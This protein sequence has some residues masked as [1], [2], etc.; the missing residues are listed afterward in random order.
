MQRSAF[1]YSPCGEQHPQ[2]RVEAACLTGSSRGT[3]RRRA[4]RLLLVRAACI[5]ILGISCRPTAAEVP[6]TN[7]APVYLV[8]D[9]Q[10]IPDGDRAE[11]LLAIAHITPKSAWRSV[12]VPGPLTRVAV[13]QIIWKYVGLYRA[14]Y[15]QTM[16]ALV[17]LVWDSNIEQHSSH[18]PSTVLIPP[19]PVVGNLVYN[20][21]PKMRT[22]EPLRQAYSLSSHL[23]TLKSGAPPD[24]RPV[25]QND[26]RRGSNLTA[27]EV[28]SSAELLKEIF[29]SPALRSILKGS[30]LATTR[31][32]FAKAEV[33]AAKPTACNG[34]VD[35]LPTS[36]YRPL[37]ENARPRNTDAA[38]NSL[39]AKAKAHPLYV[40]DWDTDT[41]HGAKVIGAAGYILHSLGMDA[42]VPS[43]LPYELDPSKNGPTL[44]ALVEAFRN[45]RV[46][47]GFNAAILA[48]Y[49][50]NTI[51]WIDNPPKPDP[52]DPSNFVVPEFLLQSLLWKF[53]GDLS[54]Q[55]WVNMSFWINNTS[56]DVTSPSFLIGSRS[57]GFLAAG[58]D[59]TELDLNTVP[60]SGASDYPD[61]INVTYGSGDGNVFG[62]YG[63]LSTKVTVV[64]PGCGMQFGQISAS[65][66]GSSFASP[67][68]AAATWLKSLLTD[69]F[70]DQDS[71]RQRLILAS[72]PQP[73][74][75]RSIESGGNFDPALLLT[76]PGPHYV[77]P[78][79]SIVPLTSVN[80]IIGFDD[81]S[82]QAI[83][84]RSST[85]V[86]APTRT[87]A[88]IQ[89]AAGPASDY[90]I[91]FRSVGLPPTISLEIR[92]GARI[93]SVS[94][95]LQPQNGPVIMLS[96]VADLK[97]TLAELWY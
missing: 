46:V 41:G 78:Q 18:G 37:W 67:Y 54:Q 79:G 65:D 86:T 53:F 82:Q 84:F 28:P 2:W 83:A 56:L 20:Y 27:I 49:T 4:H 8:F 96:N 81:G 50:S 72:R 97:N 13:E 32:G 87:L 92:R 44:K 12:R 90:C 15:P 36:P 29:K 51:D 26:P 35:W 19:V 5:C 38:Y 64:A 69:S 34:P 70:I 43:I 9:E 17:D 62:A 80:L 22:F 66:Y 33:A 57:I 45:E 3:M 73:N 71:V 30:V 93:H 39:L 21:A 94:G 11:L 74:Q 24:P 1:G 68:V 60:Q 58:N 16:K 91:W 31:N 47:A 25:F 59:P 95:E 10:H 76:T 6:Q 52:N 63:G 48:L 88:I 61:L 42:L 7:A 75:T 23:S 85:G 89:C 40:V 77:T 14:K 55:Y